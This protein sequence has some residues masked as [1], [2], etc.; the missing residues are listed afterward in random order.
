[1][2]I[3][4][5]NGSTALLGSKDFFLYVADSVDVTLVVSFFEIQPDFKSFF[6]PIDAMQNCSWS[7]KPSSLPLT[8]NDNFFP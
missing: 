7:S 4:F 6:K 3:V 1:M 8:M 2:S 5:F